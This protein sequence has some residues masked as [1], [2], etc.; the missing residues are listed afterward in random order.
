MAI[1]H[2]DTV[3]GATLVGIGGIVIALSANMGRGAA[4]A[5]LPPNFFPLMCAFGLIVCG[6]ILLVKGLRSEAGPLPAL[7]DTRILVVGGLL[8]IFYWFFADIDFRLGAWALALVTMLMFGIRNVLQ[9]VLIPLGLAIL[10]YLAFTRGFN[11]VL[12]TW[13]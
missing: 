13:I 12:P 9:L 5:T 2:E 8:A 1:K 7:V 3:S 6:V 4:G 11:V 10:L